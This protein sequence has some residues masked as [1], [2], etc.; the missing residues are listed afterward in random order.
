MND[1]ANS[2]FQRYYSKEEFSDRFVKN[3]DEA[4]DVIIPVLHTNELWKKN[5]LSFYREIPI[6]RLL[7]GDGGC[8]DDSIEIVNEFPRVSVFN[9]KSYKTLGYSIRKLIEAVDTDWFVYLHSDVYLPD[10]WFDTMKRYQTEYDWF[11]CP[12]QH[13]VMVEYPLVPEGRPYAGSQIG[14]KEAFQEGLSKIDDDYVYRQ[15]DFVFS[16]LVEQ[17][18][19]KQG[20]VEDTFHY[21]QTMHKPSPWYRKVK[22]VDI[23]VEMSQEEEV[24]TFMMQAK[25]IIKYLQPTP[26]LASGVSGSMKRLQKLG[27]LNWHEFKQW[28]AETNT[29]W[30]PY[31]RKAS[32][33]RQWLHG[34]LR[35]FYR[36]FLR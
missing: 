22:S 19:Y 4:I 25:G 18:G 31:I 33:Y 32:P 13:T 23:E 26:I 12:M 16:D 29:V 15:E 8:I 34:L 36:L 3:L 24:R 30:L 5:L 7:I 14:R 9:H 28:V 11:G 1:S 2:I 6:S 35:V 17:A 20:Y 27:A 10:G 21:H